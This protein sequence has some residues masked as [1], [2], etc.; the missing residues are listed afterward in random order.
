MTADRMQFALVVEREPHHYVGYVPDLIWC[1]F[2]GRTAEDAR[3]A[4]IEGLESYLN[5]LIEDG[6]PLPEPL[7]SVSEVEATLPGFYGPVGS[8]RFKVVVEQAP[9][10]FSAFSPDLPGCVSVGDTVDE[11]LTMM[12]EAIELHLESMAED[13]EELPPKAS[14]VG[15]AEVG[16]SRPAPV[17]AASG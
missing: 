14:Y 3:Q 9:S 4:T 8:A 5:G 10:N 13:L 7:A 1:M 6:D 16:L 17:E 11:T 12:R 2:R 15:M